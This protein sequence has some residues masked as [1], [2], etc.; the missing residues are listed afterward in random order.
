M[1]ALMSILVILR[2]C[3][4]QAL[5]AFHCAALVEYLLKSE[6]LDAS[7]HDRQTVVRAESCCQVSNP[8]PPAD[9]PT[10]ARN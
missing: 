6:P 5:M 7:P 10:P 4:L 3:S 8:A 2:R 1:I 9:P